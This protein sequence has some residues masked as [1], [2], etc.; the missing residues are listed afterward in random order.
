MLCQNCH[1]RT[2]NVHFTQVVN[3]KKVE[4]YLCEECAKE[5]GQFSFGYP[6]NMSGLFTGFMGFGDT[7]P[8]M[9]S[10]VEK[11][12]CDKCGMDYNQ[13]QKTGKMGCA[14]CYQ[15]FDNKLRPIIRRVHGNVKHTGKVPLNVSESLKVSKEIEKLKELLNKAVLDEEYE[16]AAEL[17]DKIKSLEVGS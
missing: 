5:K 16:K 8:Y 15:V 7:Q 2:A 9:E 1:K 10:A 4:M 3:N 11:Q 13:F 14:N 17:R 12:V 6:F